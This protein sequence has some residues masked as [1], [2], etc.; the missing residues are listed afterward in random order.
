MPESNTGPT[1]G[2][3][4]VRVR[5][6]PLWSEQDLGRDEIVER[7]VA[8]LHEE[9][10]H[11][12][13]VGVYVLSDGN[14]HLQTQRGRPT[15]HETIPVGQGI[16][17]A[18]MRENDTIV[19]PDVKKDERYLACNLQTSSEIVVPIRVGP[20][21]VAQIDIDSDRPDAFGESDRRFLQWLAARLGPLFT[22]A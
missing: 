21:P 3:E 4:N 18:A 8:I 12:D 9:I 10:D 5:L 6:E 22:D 2:F 11:F 7:I 17:G 19:V 15:P 13:W 20:E 14:L 16:C 1:A